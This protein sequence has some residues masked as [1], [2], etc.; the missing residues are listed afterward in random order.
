MRMETGVCVLHLFCKRGDDIDREAVTAAIE[1]AK[2]RQASRPIRTVRSFFG[3]LAGHRAPNRGTG[4]PSEV[5][6]R[7]ELLVQAQ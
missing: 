2:Q 6:T 4:G 7:A 3:L 1:A 5:G